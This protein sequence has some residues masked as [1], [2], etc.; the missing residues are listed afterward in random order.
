MAESQ[1]VAERPNKDAAPDRE[2][3]PLPV[4]VIPVISND[5]D[6]LPV[7]RCWQPPSI[8]VGTRM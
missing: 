1:D 4:P 2:I 7:S 5:I 8:L 3:A 6:N